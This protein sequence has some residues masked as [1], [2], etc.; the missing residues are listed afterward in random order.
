MRHFKAMIERARR[1]PLRRDQ[2]GVAMIEFAIAAPVFLTLTLTGLELANLALSHLK[3]N[4]MAMTVADDAGR[5]MSGIDEANIHEVFTGA[6]IIS[7]G[8][9]FKPHGRMVLSSLEPNGQTGG[10]EG[11]VITWQRCWGD[12][13]VDPAYGEEG[14]GADDDSL[15]DGMGTGARKIVAGDDTAVMVVEVS[16]EYQPLVSTGFFDPPTIR[17]ESAFNVRGRQNNAIS[18]TQGLTTFTC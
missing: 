2:D 1:H 9:D 4:Q 7:G 15:E 12:L 5:V 10:D 13:D 6:Q 18:N 14:D 3:V 17:Y 11:Q 8:L 16:Y